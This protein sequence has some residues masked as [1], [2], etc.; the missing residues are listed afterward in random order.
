MS[1]ISNLTLNFDKKVRQVEMGKI[2][3]LNYFEI[4]LIE[5]ILGT[6]ISNQTSYFDKKKPSGKFF[7]S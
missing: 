4:G 3:T 5:V 2:L 1:L 6:L 7:R